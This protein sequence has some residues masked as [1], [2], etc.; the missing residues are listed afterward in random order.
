MN[1]PV[2][3]PLLGGNEKKYLSEC[4]DTGWIS[5]EGPFVMRFENDFAERIGVS[6][7]GIAT[8]N[9]TAALETAL[10]ALGVGEGDEVIMPTFTI[11]SC[12]VA[13]LR[14]GAIPVL[15]DIDPDYWCMNTD[16]I[17][18]RITERTKVIMAVHIYGS[19]VNMQPLLEL[20]KRYNLL[21]LEDMAE[22]IGSQYIVSGTDEIKNCGTIGDAAAVS[23]YANK[24]ITTG[25]GGMVLTSDEAIAKRARQYRNLC[26]GREE[27][28]RHED[29]GYN[30]RMTNLQAAVGV[31]QLEQMD[32]FLAI[33]ARNGKRYAEL[34]KS[35]PGIRFMQFPEWTNGVFWM[36][37]VELEHDRGKTA[38]EVMQKLRLMGIGTRP[39]FLGLHDQDILQGKISAPEEAFPVSDAS[40]KYGFYLPSGINLNFK[41]I[42]YVYNCLQEIL[43]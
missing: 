30:F 11:I 20:K 40:Y 19:S 39:F 1:V 3:T 2:N 21:I 4:I 14:L 9:G 25:E 32:N 10:Y 17:E 18:S 13:C 28:F 36:Y 24:L 26:F 31:A 27:R 41:Q 7:P 37:A 38:V 42:E 6:L 23:F 15:V 33:K 16:Q 12:A 43:V 22:A 8:C 29:I 35:L 34:L 5:S